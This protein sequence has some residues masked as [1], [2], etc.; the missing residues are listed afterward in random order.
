MFP[1]FAQQDYSIAKINPALLEGADAVIR[2]SETQW[3]ILSKAEARS[4]VRIAVTILNERGEEKY[5]SFQVGYDKF[6]KITDISGNLYDASGKSVKKLRANEIADFGQGDGADDITDSRMKSA[7]FGRKSYPYPYTVE[8]SYETRDRNMMFY[9]RW[10]P[11]SNPKAS[12]ELSRFVIKAPAGF[13]FRY[14]EYNGAPKVVITKNVD[15]ADLYEWQMA[16]QPVEKKDDMY[17]LPLTDRIPM[18]IA[19]P[20]EFEI[21]D[22]KGNFNSW[23]DLSRFYYTLNAGRD[24]LPPATIAE[25]DKL[26]KDAKTD[27]EKIRLVYKWM[28]ARSR[29]VSIQLGIGGWQTIDALT[30]AGKGYGDC[31]A[32][33]N[34]TIAALKQAGIPAYAALIRSGREASMMEDFPSSQFNHVIACALA[35]KDTLWLECT[36]Q[37]VQ[38]NFMGTFTGGRSALLVM[39]QGGRLVRT[40]DYK[41]AQ[42][43]RTSRVR[44]NL[45]QT[46]TGQIETQVL[47]TGLQQE[48]RS[49]VLHGINKEEQKKWLMQQINLPSM[50][51][52][53]FELSESMAGE[54][55]VTE[56]LSMNVRNCATKTGTRLFVK[57]SLMARSFELPADTDRA[58]D[59]YLPHSAYNFTDVD[60]IAYTIP[61]DYALE[62]SLPAFKIESTFGLYEMKSSLLN[63]QLVCW[64]KV[65]INGG[66]YPSKDFAAWVDF[67]KKIRKADRAQVV[68]VEKKT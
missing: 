60:T 32:L 48:L 26:V 16:Q 18:V 51:L 38:P 4:K 43:T 23:E 46:G 55:E 24:K 6:T 28:Q 1:A 41:A 10:M 54:P 52:L 7:D 58:T 65:V 49:A 21:Q 67:L 50:D 34:F 42:N 25:I 11:A 12:V 47:Y 5:N 30:V 64:R 27:H 59:F 39:P 45:E 44:V 37:K 22:Y 40:P 31:K 17:P 8:F 33:T 36:S 14:K 29:Y 20:A 62:T 3:E 63:N 9:P 2:F 19:A 57:P 15:N 61:A 35:G 13:V 56:K 53:R 68:F 66:R